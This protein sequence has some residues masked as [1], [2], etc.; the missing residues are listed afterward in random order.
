VSLPP[1]R[2]SQ[3]KHYPGIGR[4]IYC[5]ADD[6]SLLT[7]E[8]VIPLSLGGVLIFDKASCERCNKITRHF[9]TTVA[10]TMFGPFRVKHNIKTRH[11]NERPSNF[12]IGIIDKSGRSR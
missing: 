2:S 8:H 3:V 12:E 7:N 4:C 1:P 11:K 9:E 6:P 10:R 5:G